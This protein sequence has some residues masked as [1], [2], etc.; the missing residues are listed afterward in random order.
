MKEKTIKLINDYLNLPLG[1]QNVS[2][3]YYNNKK[4]GSRIGLRVLIGKGLPQEIIDE[5]KIFAIKQKINLQNLTNDELKK[6]LV[7]NNLGIDCSGLVYHLLN[8]EFGNLKLFYPQAKNIFRKIIIKMRPVEN[9]SVLILHNEKNS[10]E[11][12]LNE[13]QTGNFII[14]L[15]GG[16]QKNYNHIIFIEKV[17]KE[18]NVVKQIDYIHSFKWPED[19]LYNHGVRRGKIEIT[20]INKN[21]LEQNWIEKDKTGENNWTL[22]YLKTAEKVK[23]KKLK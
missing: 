19:G 11:I 10:I 13:I 18:N 9:T 21:I 17:V 15:N 16:S 8:A 23:I 22:T 3:P 4:K 7:E 1:A 12:N 2:C 5:A 20:D 6:F 14:S